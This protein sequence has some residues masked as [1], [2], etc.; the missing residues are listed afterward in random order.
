MYT[1]Y[2][3]QIMSFLELEQDE[4][5]TLYTDSQSAQVLLERPSPDKRS[6]HLDMRFFRCQQSIDEGLVRLKFSP[7]ATLVPDVMTKAT[8]GPR[9]LM[10]TTPMMDGLMGKVQ[11]GFGAVGICGGV[12]KEKNK[13]MECSR[14]IER[15]RDR[16]R[17]PRVAGKKVVKWI[18]EL[19]REEA[20]NRRYVHCQRDV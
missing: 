10:L 5:T 13:V 3:R 20:M 11:V 7:S 4:P 2:F 19:D 9:H 18:D 14:E 12:L 15:S 1:E 16:E 8:A 6:K 17:K